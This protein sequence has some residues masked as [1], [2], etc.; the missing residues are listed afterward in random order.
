MSLLPHRAIQRRHNQRENNEIKRLD[1]LG[2][3]SSATAAIV[4]P[5]SPE[6]VKIIVGSP[7]TRRGWGGNASSINTDHACFDSCVSQGTSRTVCSRPPS[8]PHSTSET[9]VSQEHSVSRR[10]CGGGRGRAA[11]SKQQRLK[12]CLLSHRQS[13]RYLMTLTMLIS[14][15][16]VSYTHLTLPTIY[17]V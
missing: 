4:P 10:D 3:T 15:A 1:K 12:R 17:S 9:D 7:R 14:F 6:A 5:T 11:S 2:N 8:L 16:A 13:Q